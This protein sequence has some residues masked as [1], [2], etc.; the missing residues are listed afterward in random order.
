M[1]SIKSATG[2]EDS[3]LSELINKSRNWKPKEPEAAKKI[4]D[5][6]LNQLSSANYNPNKKA[7]SFSGKDG[8]TGNTKLA[9]FIEG[10]LADDIKL[11]DSRNNIIR[12]EDAKNKVTLKKNDEKQEIK[13]EIDNGSEPKIVFGLPLNELTDE[14]VNNHTNYKTVDELLESLN[15]GKK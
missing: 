2:G 15:K 7:I 5:I 14:F 11:R 10:L 1:I 8:K 4:S 6:K 3:A 9:E 12:I 13:V